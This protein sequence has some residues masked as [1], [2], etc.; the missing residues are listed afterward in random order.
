[1]Y[2]RKIG[3]FVSSFVFLALVACTGNKFP[4]QKTPISSGMSGTPA[5]VA[6]WY[7]NAIHYGEKYCNEADIRK[8]QQWEGGMWYYDGARIFYQLADF[9]GSSHWSKCADYVVQTYRK[10]VTDNGGKIPGWRVFP[11]GLSDHYRRTGDRKS[12]EA[13]LMLAGN[14]AFAA[15]AGGSDP[16]L[17]RET[18]FLIHSYLLAREFG[19]SSTDSLLNKAV[20]YQLNHMRAWTTV[21]S[22]EYVKPFMIG[23]AMEALIAYHKYSNDERIL[24]VVKQAADWLWNNAW[25]ARGQSFPYI[26][27]EPGATQKECAGASK[28]GT[29]DLNLLIAPAYAWLYFVTGES[30]YAEQGDAIFSGGVRQADLNNGKRFSQSYRWSF[31]Y[32]NWRY[33]ITGDRHLK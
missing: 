32:L 8:H 1:M 33:G 21:E 4:L 7:K 25:D 9:T 18:S 26:I 16:E 20:T 22:T 15:T 2:H 27:C 30:R 13:V 17:S 12:R 19:L 14:S 10:Y 31:D 3:N 6:T 29:A 23:L 24:L 11:H 28:K 5:S